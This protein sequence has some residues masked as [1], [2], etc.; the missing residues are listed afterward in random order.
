VISALHAAWP[1][2]LPQYRPKMFTAAM[3]A[4][5][6]SGWHCIVVWTLSGAVAG[7][8]WLEPQHE[9]DPALSRWINENSRTV[10][11]LFVSPEHRGKSLAIHLLTYARSVVAQNLRLRGLASFVYLGNNASI[12]AHKSSGFVNVAYVTKRFCFGRPAIAVE[13]IGTF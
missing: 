7:A 9:R 1:N 5:F 6:A 4:R 12:R 8:A 3:E 13:T 2:E 11:N 10:V